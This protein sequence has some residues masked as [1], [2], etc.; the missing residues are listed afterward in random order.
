MNKKIGS[1][2]HFPGKTSNKRYDPFLRIPV[3]EH[4]TEPKK[5][6]DDLYD[7]WLWQTRGLRMLFPRLMGPVDP[8][9]ILIAPTGSGKTLLQKALAWGCAL[10]GNK[11]VIAVPESMVIQQFGSDPKRY[12]LNVPGMYET[13]A[14][15]VPGGN[16]LKSTTL[17]TFSEGDALCEERGTVSRL[18]RFITSPVAENVEERIIV[19]TH[20]ALVAAF[21]QITKADWKNVALFIDEAHHSKY[22]DDEE[23]LTATEAQELKDLNG[24]LAKIVKHYTHVP[25]AGRLMLTTATWLRGDG[26]TIVPEENLHR[27]ETFELEMHE[28]LGNQ[29]PRGHITFK[30]SLAKNGDYA[31]FV[32][33]EF[34]RDPN[35]NTIT[36]LPPV[37]SLGWSPAKKLS[38]LKACNRALGKHTKVVRN[39]AG[40]D[41]VYGSR[42]QLTPSTEI[43]HVEL[44]TQKGR[45]Q[46]QDEFFRSMHNDDSQVIN[47]TVQNKGREAFDWPQLSRA[48][49]LKPRRS[50]PMI[51]QM[52][53]RPLRAYSV[54]CK[55]HGNAPDEKCKKCFFKRHVEFNIVLPENML[56]DKGQFEDYTGTVFMV[57]AL[58]WL[59]RTKLPKKAR[60]QKKLQELAIE[61]QRKTFTGSGGN[62]AEDEAREALKKVFGEDN[63]SLAPDAVQTLVD[64]MQGALWSLADAA[65]ERLG[66]KF[67]D[68]CEAIYENPYEGSKAVYIAL[69]GEKQFQVLRDAYVEWIS[70]D[71]LKAEVKRRKITAYDDYLRRYK[72]IPGA[73]VAPYK[74]YAE[75]VSWPDLFGRKVDGRISLDQL[76]AE[77]KRLKITFRG[78]YKSGYQRRYKERHKEIYGA[79]ARPALVYSEWVSWPDLFGW[80]VEDRISLDHLRLEVKRRK[81]TSGTD[82]KSRY[83]EIPGAPS[84]PECA[85][86]DTDGWV[87]WPDLFGRKVKNRISLDHLRLEVK[88]RKITS[89][90]DYKSRY[91]E[92]PGAPSDPNIVYSDWINW[93]DLFGRKVETQSRLKVEDRISLDQLKA[94]VKRRKITSKVDYKSR[95]K[96]ILGAHSN[97][98]RAYSDWINWPDLFGRVFRRGPDPMKTYDKCKKKFFA[99]QALL[100]W[101]WQWTKTNSIPGDYWTLCGPMFTET[102][103][104][105]EA[106]ASPVELIELY[107]AGRRD[108]SFGCEL[109]HVLRSG[110]LKAPQFHAVELDPS[111]YEANVR[112]IRPL[113]E[114]PKLYHGDIVQVMRDALKT[115]KLQPSIVNLDTL[116]HPKKAMALLGQVLDIVNQ[117]PVKKMIA[118]NIILDDPYRAKRNNL[119][120]VITAENKIQ[121]KL[122]GWAPSTEGYVYPGTGRTNIKML[123]RFYFHPGGGKHVVSP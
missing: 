5:P 88:R 62:S 26:L 56:A 114:H 34:L 58:G 98:N 14:W 120:E 95:Y 11:V 108:L 71:Q 51:I 99:R 74:V 55:K 104:F 90:T 66:D 103:R 13:L 47:L 84:N 122:Q 4:Y 119:A 100:Y 46:R 32:R 89:V 113:K 54:G 109:S 79:P 50:L 2:V 6:V 53:G 12:N 121:A 27:F 17:K 24:A 3:G 68:V 102:G 29:L 60:T 112:A 106:D 44:V 28:H 110:Y 107:D 48:L 67:S 23:E 73:P 16:L 72:E 33:E 40:Q 77:L 35:Q 92:I 80:K 69:A 78:G 43:L 65:K 15:K 94:E 85:Y 91:K 87:S 116:H 18:K 30:F 118:L 123:T 97:P 93:P 61:L 49:V 42:H 81:I 105:A 76:K 57:M 82:Y 117:V 96:E 36:Y 31:G 111:T 101:W 8:F 19:C 38:L 41:F 86:A 59:F 22:I 9:T 64:C 83:K 21:K 52:F 10:N 7:A 37:N 115:G 1:F 75:W 39:Y 45:E 20:A 63:E 70:L 25:D